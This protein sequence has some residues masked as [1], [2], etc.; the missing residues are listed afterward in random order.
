MGFLLGM[1]IHLSNDPKSAMWHIQKHRFTILSLACVLSLAVSGCDPAK[2][3]K[4]NFDEQVEELQKELDKQLTPTRQ[5][6]LMRP[7]VN[8]S[9]PDSKLHVLVRIL[10]MSSLEKEPNDLMFPYRSRLQLMILP[11]TGGALMGE[12]PVAADK[13]LRWQMPSAEQAVKIVDDTLRERLT[14]Q[15]YGF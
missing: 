8:A 1:R 9:E 12:C 14:P 2:R 4:T 13:R 3:L 5:V 10:T 7:Y 15:K 6:S 11:S